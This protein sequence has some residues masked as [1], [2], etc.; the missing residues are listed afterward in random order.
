MNTSIPDALREVIADIENE[1]KR[2]RLM[3]LL[4]AQFLR[5]HMTWLETH[6]ADEW[7]W[8]DWL[9]PSWGP[10]TEG[11][12]AGLSANFPD[13]RPERLIVCENLAKWFEEMAD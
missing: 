10:T 6:G 11:I 1:Q 7:K 12:V 13:A 3:F 2:M 5:Q 8:P 9:D 4:T